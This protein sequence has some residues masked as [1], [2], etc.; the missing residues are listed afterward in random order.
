M[1]VVGIFDSYWCLLVWLISEPTIPFLWLK[2]PLGVMVIW[3]N[4]LPL[5]L[6]FSKCNSIDSVLVV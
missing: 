5:V 2:V 1:W 4:F 3:L 6:G